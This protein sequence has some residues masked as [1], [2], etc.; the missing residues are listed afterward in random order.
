MA[1]PAHLDP[2]CPHKR[3]RRPEK[4]T[5][6]AKIQYHQL[7][8]YVRHLY[9]PRV[10]SHM[11]SRIMFVGKKRTISTCSLWSVALHHHCLSYQRFRLTHWPTHRTQ[12]GFKKGQN[13][14]CRMGELY[15]VSL[16]PL[17][18]AS[19]HKP[20]ARGWLSAKPRTRPRP[21]S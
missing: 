15:K 18:P 3:E 4:K 8:L 12:R 10:S 2:R 13:D 11:E 5:K 14:A 21:F 6:Q 16:I 1:A 19:P 9:R 20:I 17:H 7:M